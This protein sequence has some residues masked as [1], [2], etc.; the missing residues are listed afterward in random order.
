MTWELVLYV[1][2]SCNLWHAKSCDSFGLYYLI[3]TQIL[4]KKK[5]V[6]AATV[7][8]WFISFEQHQSLNIIIKFKS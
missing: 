8:T 3:F 2:K 1:L 6:S 5:G 7:N 4:W